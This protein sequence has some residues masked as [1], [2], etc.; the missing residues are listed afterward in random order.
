[1]SS[2]APPRAARALAKPLGSLGSLCSGGTSLTTAG[3]L[4]L[5]LGGCSRGQPVKVQLLGM[6]RSRALGLLLETQ[7]TK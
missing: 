7:Y 2:H 3:G 6:G 4:A 5:D 1:M